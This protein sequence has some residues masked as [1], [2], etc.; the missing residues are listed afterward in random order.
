M[1]HYQMPLNSKHIKLDF[2]PQH[3]D[4]ECRCK[5]CKKLLAKI[6]S[7]DKRMVIEIKCTRAHCGLINTFEV[8]RNI[9]YQEKQKH[10]EE[11]I[12]FTFRASAI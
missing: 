5:N 11:V 12:G 4:G 8:C 9:N 7:V 6:K 2:V 3:T 1:R 10:Q